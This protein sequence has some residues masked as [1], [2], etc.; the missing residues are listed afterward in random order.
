MDDLW[1]ITVE[2]AVDRILGRPRA[3]NPYSFTEAGDPHDA[4][5]AGWNEADFLLELRGQQEARRW[6]GEAA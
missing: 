6:L 5:D 2:G 4:W 1:V 3:R